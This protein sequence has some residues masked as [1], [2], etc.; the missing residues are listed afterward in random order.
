[1][2]PGFPWAGLVS[3]WTLDSCPSSL[4]PGWAKLVSKSDM[5][6]HHLMPF[7]THLLFPS[8]LLPPLFGWKTKKSSILQSN[9]SVFLKV[10][11]LSKGNFHF[12]SLKLQCFEHLYIHR[13]LNMLITMS[14]NS[15]FPSNYSRLE[16][17][18]WDNF[19]MPIPS[20]PI[21]IW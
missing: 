14:F 11:C 5:A 2:V 20:C 16:S 4:C 9:V 10:F 6:P 7:H 15:I 17:K 12:L 8:I 21:N 13:E 3:L 19:W 1:M 18:N